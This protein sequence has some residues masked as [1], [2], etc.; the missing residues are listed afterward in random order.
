LFNKSGKNPNGSEGLNNGFEKTIFNK[1]RS[2]NKAGLPNEKVNGLFY[3]AAGLNIG[4]ILCG[5]I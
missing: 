5:A 2:Y 4:D 1:E 3:F